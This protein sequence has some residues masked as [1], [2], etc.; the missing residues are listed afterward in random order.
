M[1]A[2]MIPPTCAPPHCPPFQVFLI[3]DHTTPR[4]VSLS[5]HVLSLSDTASD[6]TTSA[7]AGYATAAPVPGVAAM[8]EPPSAVEPA[9]E[10][11]ANAPANFAALVWS[12]PTEDL[13]ATRPGCSATN[14]YI[15]V[16][17]VATPPA[18][19]GATSAPT[20]EVSEAQVWLAP[21]KDINLPQP[22]LRVGDMKTEADGSL[23]F[24]LSASRPAALT[25][26]STPSAGHFSDDALT[27]LHP[28]EPV[29]LR[30]VP[31][32]TEQPL[33]AEQLA[34][35]LSVTSLYDHQF[36]LAPPSVAA[37]PPLRTATG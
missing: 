20:P 4:N 12:E 7:G 35:S 37:V 16:R 36:G 22:D 29:R 11:K 8:P 1:I 24:L 14:C 31:A 15:A 17:A 28:C 34:E 25:Q 23:S 2:A 6:C 19:A 9:A 13:L 30:F 5:V 26:L 3:N 10:F 21:L 32:A 33:D 18:V 27:A